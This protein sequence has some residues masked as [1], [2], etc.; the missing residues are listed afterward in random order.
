MMKF[1][2]LT[3]A[4]LSASYL[5]STASADTVKLK[6]GTTLTGKILSETPTSVEI[7]YHI[8]KGI[9][10]IR[11][12][13]RADISTDGIQKESPDQSA[14]AKIAKLRSTP[15]LLDAAGYDAIIAGEPTDFMEAFKDSPLRDDVQ[16]VIDELLAEKAKATA[17]GIKIDGTWISAKEAAKDRYNHPARVLLAHM[18][19][20]LAARDYGTAMVRFEELKTD[21]LFSASFIEAI[22]IGKAA[23]ASYA[24]QLVGLE[25]THAALVARRESN[26]K[27][28]DPNNRLRTEKAFAKLSDAFTQRR[29]RADDSGQIWL[30]VSKWDLESITEAIAITE[31]ESENLNKIDIAKT[32][33]AA[34]LLASA[35]QS[36]SAGQFSEA[37]VQLS[38]AS[39][40]GAKGEAIKQLGEDI[41]GARK[42]ADDAAKAAAEAAADAAAAALLNPLGGTAETPDGTT[43]PDG[44]KP[45]GDPKAATDP[46]AK[47]PAEAKPEPPK[48]KAE[49]KKEGLGM[50]KIL[51]ILA[52][53]LLV[54]TLIAKVFIKPSEEEKEEED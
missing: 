41:R 43:P 34:G 19:A 33:S 44:T 10:D 17:G 31:S 52:G 50:Q 26:L 16:T 40:A 45:T 22:P 13:P 37:A 42:A 25:D 51:M 12:V 28:M 32:K 30:P 47:D 48:R 49:K 53:L 3:I 11:V 14:F 15:D 46:K 54:V 4:L 29:T 39:S 9:N 1:H 21:Y 24:A 27:T 23:I 35:F 38:L 18:K 6:D 36:Y 5:L 7:E 2:H 20:D 8:S